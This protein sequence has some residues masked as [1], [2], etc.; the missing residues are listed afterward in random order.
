MSDALFGFTEDE[1]FYVA[2]SKK[3]EKLEGDIADLS[4][5]EPDGPFFFD[6][7][8]DDFEEDDSPATQ[9]LIEMLG[10]DPDLEFQ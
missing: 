4:S 6:D 7:D 10:F 2:G 9:E 3:L 8:G 1:D 5:N